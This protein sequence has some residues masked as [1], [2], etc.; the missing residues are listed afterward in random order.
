[1]K[2]L[3]QAIFI[4]AFL[5]TLFC[6]FPAAAE[7]P[8]VSALAAV[9]TDRESGRIL[10][11]KDEHRRLPIA[12]TTKIMTA[13]LA[14]EH[15]CEEDLITVSKA[16]ASTEG[17]SIWLDEGEKKTLEELIYGLM[18]RSGN[19]AA[20]AIAEHIGGTEKNFV[21]MMNRKAADLGATNTL[22]ANPH[23]LPDGPQYSTA[24]DLGLIA[25]RA[26]E[27]ERFRQIIATP[28][29]TI[30]WPGRPWDRAMANQ[31]RLLELY[32]GGDGVKTGW[33]KA[34]GRC[35]VGSAT[36]EGW[37]LVCVVLN[38]PQMWED[39]ILLLDYGFENYRRQ[40]IM[41]RNQ[42]LCTAPVSKG[43]CRV[44]VAVKEDLHLPLLPGE[45][46][47]LHCRI[48]LDETIRAPL[49]EGVKIGEAEI[50]LGN[51]L[52]ARAGLCSGH[53]VGKRGPLSY[54]REL[55]GYLLRG[56]VGD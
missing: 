23:G 29:W 15:G 53:A 50:Y 6:S 46:K 27:N 24:S 56:E 8:E 11:A 48:V 44:D 16:A 35:F 17:S 34:A 54:C 19:D 38:A 43:T 13:L 47:S 14:L 5:L 55:I 2:K 12:S 33:T 9:L 22:F 10:W 4:A 3:P 30:S 1:M 41:C 32:P 36:R 45:E 31:N 49:A 26:L 18:L 25:C 28:T 40:K 20:V 51:E 37:Q 42:V 21:L 52:L 7:E 39:A